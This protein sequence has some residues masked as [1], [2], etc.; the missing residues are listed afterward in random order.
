MSQARRNAALTQAELAKRIGVSRTS[1]ANLERGT[2]GIQLHDLYDVAAA[3]D[4]DIHHL[5]PSHQPRL[6]V[7]E[8]VAEKDILDWLQRATDTLATRPQRRRR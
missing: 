7:L 2:Q 6:K 5:I 8:A 3:L 1:I 4:V